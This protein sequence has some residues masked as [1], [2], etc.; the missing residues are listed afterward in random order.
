M[1]APCKA[2]SVGSLPRPVGFARPRRARNPHIQATAR[3][4]PRPKAADKRFKH[5]VP[6][7]WQLAAQRQALAVN[8]KQA[9]GCAF[10]RF[11]AG[12]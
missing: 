6:L 9:G 11:N 8:H 12:R 10:K 4:V 5:G 7:R 1:K 3:S 2:Q